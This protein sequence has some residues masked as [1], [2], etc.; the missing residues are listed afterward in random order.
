MTG[1][2]TL[3]ADSHVGQTA[4]RKVELDEGLNNTGQGSLLWVQSSEKASL[5]CHI[6]AEVSLKRMCEHEGKEVCW[7]LRY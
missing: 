4:P 3:Q 5:G 7:K 1:G 2:Y 6:Q